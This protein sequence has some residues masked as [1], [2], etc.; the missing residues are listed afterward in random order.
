MPELIRAIERAPEQV[1]HAVD[2]QLGRGALEIAR[3]MRADAPKAQ[4]NLVNSIHASKDAL[5][6]WRVGPTAEHAWYVEHG[7]QPGAR[8]P[9]LSALE[10]WVMTKLQIPPGRE[11][12]GVAFAIGRAIARRGIP[13][14]P[15]V[16]PI[17]QDPRWQQRIE[18]LARV[19][20]Q[21]GLT[22]AGVR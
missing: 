19:G 12:R 10:D 15:F 16:R 20:I 13:A 8:M 6:S 11:R 2:V 17:A 7:R 3:Q 22:A 9:P 4:S 5:L 14:R 21:N 1:T 18:E